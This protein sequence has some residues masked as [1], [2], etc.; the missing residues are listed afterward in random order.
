MS[1]ETSQEKA[2]RNQN[3]KRKGTPTYA[4]VRLDSEKQKK[5]INGLIEKFDG[6]KK[7]SLIR[8]YELLEK[9]LEN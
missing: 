6:T 3:E 1:K 5:W 4:A 8:A 9:E 7:G 2:N